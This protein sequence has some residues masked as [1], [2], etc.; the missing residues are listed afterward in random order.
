MPDLLLIH[1]DQMRRAALGTRPVILAKEADMSTLD[2]F[3]L[4][5]AEAEEAIQL[6]RENGY[7][8][9]AQTLPEM[10]RTALGIKP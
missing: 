9:P 10:V 4:R 6:L 5:L 8:T 7:G 2:R 3:A 1:R